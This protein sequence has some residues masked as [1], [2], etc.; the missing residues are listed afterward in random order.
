MNNQN[1]IFY[2]SEL[3]DR[4]SF[5]LR[6]KSL[7]MRCKSVITQSRLQEYSKSTKILFY[8][9]LFFF[10]FSPSSSL[11]TLKFSQSVMS[12]INKKN[13]ELVHRV[14]L[15]IL[16]QNSLETNIFS[17]RFKKLLT[18]ISFLKYSNTL[19]CSL[20]RYYQSFFYQ[21]YKNLALYNNISL[22]HIRNSKTSTSFSFVMQ[23]MG[24]KIFYSR[25]L[26]MLL[27][28]FL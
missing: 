9:I 5:F 11:S 28:N 18:L 10:G 12:S 13:E 8:F 1:N 3:A 6:K 24:C 20:T 22:T 14:L 23:P 26:N 2:L 25:Q 21:F 16:K 27:E 7:T 19:A 15:T 4:N 17:L